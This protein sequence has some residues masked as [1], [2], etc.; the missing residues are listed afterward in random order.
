LFF[1]HV[2]CS[3]P[4]CSV[5]LAFACPAF[6]PY[7]LCFRLTISLDNNVDTHGLLWRPTDEGF[8]WRATA[9]QSRVEGFALQSLAERQALYCCLELKAGAQSECCANRGADGDKRAPEK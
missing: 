6:L 1:F 3:L 2:F 5:S 9:T 8:M 4:F 7:G